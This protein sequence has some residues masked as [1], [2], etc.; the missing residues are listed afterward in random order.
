MRA[1]RFGLLGG[2]FDPPHLAHLALGRMA[3]QALALDELRWLPAGAPWQKA[4]RTMA[5][6]EHRAGMLAA[7]LD[8]EPHCVIDTRELQRMGPTYTITTVRELQAER[9]DADWFFILGQDQYGRFDTWRDWPE[10][11]QR[12]TLAVA[13]RDGQA[14]LP[15]AALVAVP[16]RV[17]A[18]PLPRLDIA[19]SDIR[20]RLSAGLPVTALVGEAV[21][22][23]IDQHQPYPRGAAQGNRH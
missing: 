11:L 20:S 19:A 18:L 1:A 4:G 8:D 17:V 16:H 15:P 10:L 6:P 5:A 14:P 3:V 21:A 22:G 2:S 23:Y 13:A 9:P 12:L 7:L